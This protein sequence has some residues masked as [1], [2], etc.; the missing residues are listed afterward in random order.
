MLHETI[1]LCAQVWVVNFAHAY[2]HMVT[3]NDIQT[4]D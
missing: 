2:M 1:G 4:E 3:T